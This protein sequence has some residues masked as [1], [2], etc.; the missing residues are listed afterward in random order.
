MES[1]S[2]LVLIVIEFLKIYTEG[3][4][5]LLGLD[6]L[7][8]SI[9]L[10][11]II[12]IIFTLVVSLTFNKLVLVFIRK[13]IGRLKL[14]IGKQMVSNKVFTPLGWAI[15]VLIFEVSLGDLSPDEGLIENFTSSL[16]IL[17]VTLTLA[18]LLSALSETLRDND[19]FSGTPVQSY[20][21][22]VKL[23]LYLFG[24]I[25]A[26]CVLT[27]TSPWTI[28]SGLGAL[29]AVIILAF[30]DTILGLVA[31][32]QVFGSDTI[33]EGDWV[34]IPSLEIDGDCVEV[35]L[36]TVTVKSFDQALITFPT[37]KLLEHPFKNWRG[38]EKAGGRRIKRSLYIDQDSIVFLNSKIKERLSKLE[39]LS[40][41]LRDKEE[42]INKANSMIKT[43]SINHR[44][45]TNVG[46]FRAY[47]LSY[48]QSNKNINQSL[49]M[50]ARQLNP[51]PN[52]L[53]L[54]V[55]AFTKTTDWVKYEENQSDIFDH[56]LAVINLFDLKLVQQVSGHDIRKFGKNNF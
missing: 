11:I 9:F 19:F 53:P 16:L 41:H 7:V 46:V 25:I 28:L 32:I 56:L 37:S 54:E 17:I 49:T 24:A 35:G 36:H 45:L 10:N 6:L 47:I 8:G 42:E 5:I 26:L 34:T 4:V 39:L 29:T 55:Y 20:F 31:S 48:L 3:F 22:L 30:R 38:I 51:G 13:W 43:D 27:S 44:Q 52:G 18:R 12:S 50:M 40:N 1:F 21:Q 23:I 14:S 33:R 15:P 2:H